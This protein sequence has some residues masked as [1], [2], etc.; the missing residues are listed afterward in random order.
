MLMAQ[1]IN[2]FRSGLGPEESVLHLLSHIYSIRFASLWKSPSLG[3]WLSTTTSAVLS[4][5]SSVHTSLIRNRFLRVFSSDLLRHS[6][7]R[8][9]IAL[10]QTHGQQ[11]H[12]GLLAF[13]PREVVNSHQYSCDPLPPPTARSRYDDT[14][15]AGVEGL[16]VPRANHR[17]T[18]AEARQLERLIP[19]PATR[20]QIIALFEQLPDAA[21]LPGG[22]VQ[23]V[24]HLRQMDDEM[25]NDLLLAGLR[26]ADP[27]ALGPDFQGHGMMPG[28]MPAE[29]NPFNDVPAMNLD[30]NA[31][32]GEEE[33]DEEEDE[34]DGGE[35][36]AVS[37]P[38][39]RSFFTFSHAPLYSRCLRGLSV[40][41]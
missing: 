21:Q 12:R 32:G 18:R 17:R 24:Q 8:H 9:V 38:A 4:Q 3:S 6:I 20:E 29:D 23:F 27:A 10:E 5:L 31:E 36:V 15:F 2:N 26:E 25:V 22:V 34:S 28:E 37:D 35:D 40:T 13:I 19:D 1:S 41:S 14:F 16:A 11:Q 39:P 33:E 30:L 7:Y